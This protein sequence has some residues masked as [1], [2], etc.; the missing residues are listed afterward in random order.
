MNEAG[1]LPDGLFVRERRVEVFFLADF[2]TGDFIELGFRFLRREEDDWGLRAGGLDIH[3]SSRRKTP[4]LRVLSGF[5][6]NQI[7]DSRRLT[8]LSGD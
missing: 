4:S 7:K 6:W 8:A 2:F 3:Q 5:V 1:R